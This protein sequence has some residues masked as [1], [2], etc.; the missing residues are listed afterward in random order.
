[1]T[2]TQLNT[3]TRQ[4]GV[5]R[6][7]KGEQTRLHILQSA[8]T[9]ISKNGIKGTT[10]RA[11]AAEADI[12]LSLTTYYFKDIKELVREAFILSSKESIENND[13]VW[14]SVFQHLT[15]YT[16]MELRKVNARKA[17]RDELVTIASEFLYEQIVFKPV[18]LAVEQVFLTEATI[19]SRI[20]RA[21]G[22]VSRRVNDPCS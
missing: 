22:R 6:R 7:A 2:D 4:R 18:G 9:V 16:K 14:E 8:R 12:Q 17:L 21:C 3:P 5:A 10:H 1:M 11:V 15:K 20:E 13:L 19:L